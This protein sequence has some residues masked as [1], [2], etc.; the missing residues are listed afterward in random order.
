MPKN[1]DAFILTMNISEI[2]KKLGKQGAFKRTTSQNIIKKSLSNLPTCVWLNPHLKWLYISDGMGYFPMLVYE[3]LLKE[4]H[5]LDNSDYNIENG[6]T[7]TD[8]DTDYK[9]QWI[10]KNMIYIVET[11]KKDAK[12]Y[13]KIFGKNA[14]ISSIDFMDSN[15]SWKKCFKGIEWFDIIMCNPPL[16]IS[17]SNCISGSN[18]ISESNCI[19]GSNRISDKYINEKNNTELYLN[20]IEKSLTMTKKLLFLI[21]NNW[22]SDSKEITELKKEINDKNNINLYNLFFEQ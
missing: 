5:F 13:I 17:E 18:C 6:Y 3:R 1:N 16:N 21:P 2:E 15:N 20:Y 7:D 4:I 11:N 12:L 19:S 9:K 10:L 14:N 8:N 22:T